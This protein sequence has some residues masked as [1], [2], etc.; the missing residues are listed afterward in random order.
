MTVRSFVSLPCATDL[1]FPSFPIL[2]IGQLG[3]TGWSYN[4]TLKY[5][6]KATNMSVAPPDLQKETHATFSPGFHG[7]SGVSNHLLMIP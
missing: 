2:E 5:F 6:K 4:N 7:N 3:N 1:Y